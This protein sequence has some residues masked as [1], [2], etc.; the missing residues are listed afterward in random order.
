MGMSYATCGGCMLTP[1]VAVVGN[2]AWKRVGEGFTNLPQGLRTFETGTGWGRP[3]RD[4][5][6]NGFRK[7]EELWFFGDRQKLLWER[8]VLEWV[9]AWKAKELRVCRMI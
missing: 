2:C 4:G 9:W 8:W 7:R 3:R 6:E 1:G 5:L